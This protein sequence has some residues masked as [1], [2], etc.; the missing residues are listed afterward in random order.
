MMIFCTQRASDESANP[1]TTMW[2]D[3]IGVART[4]R[5]DDDSAG[6]ST[7]EPR[8]AHVAS[9]GGGVFPTRFRGCPPCIV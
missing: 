7:R 4:A 3:S 2:M 9:G 8:L 1:E 6:S 5:G